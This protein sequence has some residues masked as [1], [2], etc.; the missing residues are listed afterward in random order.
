MCILKYLFFAK[1]EQKQKRFFFA[2]DICIG[3]AAETIW[4]WVNMAIIKS[5]L[6]FT[7]VVHGS[8]MFSFKKALLP[9][10]FKY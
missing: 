8:F 9:W 1:T 2:R 3:K 7:T 5:S 4:C 10:N 6:H